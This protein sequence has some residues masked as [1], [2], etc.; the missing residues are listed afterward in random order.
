MLDRW[1]GFGTLAEERRH[2]PTDATADIVPVSCHSHNDYWRLM[3]LYSAIYAGCT[4]VE[5]DVWLIDDDIRVGHR[6]I[7]TTANRT[8]QNLYIDPLMELLAKQNPTD[9]DKSFPTD[10]DEDLPVNGIFDTQPRRQLGF[11]VDFKTSG[12]ALWDKLNSQLTPLRE[13]GYLTH[14]NGSHIVDRPVIIIIS[15]NAPFDL[16]TANETYRDIFFDAPLDDL[17]DFTSWWPNPN[18]AQDPA[19][20]SHEGILPSEPVPISEPPN[21]SPESSP[22]GEKSLPSSP[23]ESDN[24]DQDIDTPSLYNPTNSYYA[25]TSFTHSIGHIFGSR[26]SQDQ[27]QKIRAQI[28][29]AHAAGLKVRYWGIPSW[30]VGLRNHI[31]HILVREGADMVNA[32]DLMGVRWGDWRRR[33]TLER[34]WSGER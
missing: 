11:L 8:L 15:G 33:R 18:R 16:V 6:R 23:P 9:P 27:L 19:R 28:H 29:G 17:A 21:S 25:S 12:P 34:W 31:W 3:P 26:L 13:K 24:D 1:S 4:S 20:G 2:W 14:F 22:V 7:T 10:F 5:A 30:P 32:D